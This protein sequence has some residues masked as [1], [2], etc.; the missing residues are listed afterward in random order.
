MGQTSKGKGMDAEVRQEERDV[1]RKVM[2][3][4]GITARA[5]GA[6]I[7]LTE[8]A[9]YKYCSDGSEN[10]PGRLVWQ[11]LYKH[12]LKKKDNQNHLN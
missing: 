6:E 10:H 9:I 8:W 11:A 5:I 4:H 2:D 12:L 3:R 1:F 7:G